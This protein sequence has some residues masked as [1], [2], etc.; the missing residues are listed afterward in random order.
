MGKPFP[1]IT[2]TVV[3]LKTHQPLQ[4]TGV[5]GLIAIK[6]VAVHVPYLLEQ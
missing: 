3:D 1:G 5:V 2:A 6:P 4:R